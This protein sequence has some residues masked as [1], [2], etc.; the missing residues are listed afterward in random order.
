MALNIADIFEHAADAFA[1]RTALICADVQL[2]YRELDE[3][4][5]RL[6]HHLASAGVAAGDRVGLYARNSAE[7]VETL[8]ATYKIRAA[9][10][11]INFRYT[12]SELQYLLADAELAGLV[13]DRQYGPQVAAA[14][15]D[16]PDIAALVAIGS[17]EPGQPEAA[18][19]GPAPGADYESALSAESGD[20]DF[21]AR[22]GDDIYLI[23]T[24][25]TT[26]HPKGVMWRHRDIWRTLGGG[27][28]FVTGERLADEWEQSRRGAQSAAGLVRFCVAPL[29]HGNAQWAAYAGLFSGDTIA[30][31]PH[32]DAH[33]IWRA[34]E[35][36]KVN[37]L[38]IIGDAMARPLIEALAEHAYDTSSLLAVS[39]SAALFSPAVKDACLAV[40]PNVVFTDAIGS[41]ETGFGG[42]SYVSAGGRQQGGPSVTPGPDTIVIGE[43][44]NRAGPG[45]TGR[46]ARGGH[47]PLGYFKDPVKTTAMFTE[48]DGVRYVVP[49]DY[50]RVEEDGTVTLLGRGNTCVNTAGEKVW[51]EEVEAALKSHPGVFDALVIGIPDDR[52]G[53]RVAALVQPR[54]RGT[55]DPA[56]PV[57][58]APGPRAPDG[59]PP[60][61]AALD[62]E[63]LD[64]HLRKRI[65]GYK[66]PRTTWLVSQIGRLP[67][68]KPDYGWARRHADELLASQ[69][70]CGT[71]AVA[72]ASGSAS[73][74]AAGAAAP[75]PG[76]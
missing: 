20:R 55:A 54:G 50:A 63:A 6:A 30:L 75:G 28:D 46:L 12:V 25:G 9:T 7:A 48:L 45:Q 76:G 16:V 42:L 69:S 13:Y 29:I 61:L 36:H 38:V 58:G 11:N 59:G 21:G 53:Q 72:T 60:G 31:I 10:V 39:S 14:L 56:A 15:A 3:R 34:V 43:D 19:A 51:P 22:S 71:A 64:L 4:A 17:R 32:F 1:G 24:G 44:G 37:L 57:P 41:S 52:L 68:G 33:A 40:L 49:G 70:G 35:R 8:L 73:D 67:S 2:T 27:I 65:A 26:G 18:A 23:Y 74:V 62:L 66:V 5:N 47:V